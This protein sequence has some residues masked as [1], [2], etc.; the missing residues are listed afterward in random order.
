MVVTSWTDVVVG[1]LQNLWFGVANYLPNIIG[2]F[3]VLVVG[4]I[5]AAG[6]GALVEKILE[7]IRLDM[8]LE[9]VG[10]KPIF[11]RAGI[12]LR[13][14]YF[15]GKLVYW[16]VIVAFLLAVADSL[17]LYALSQFL[18]SILNYL[19]NVIAAVLIMLAALVLAHFLRKLVTASVMSAKLH[20]GPF[21]GTVTWWAIVVFGFL[22]ALTQ[23]NIASA[24][25][26]TIV[27]GFI[28]MLALAGG[29]AFGLGGKDYANHLLNKLKDRTETHI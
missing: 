28:A 15:F 3:V 11:E 14:A 26:Q 13:A 23:L 16:F 2:A 8:I 5:V 7:G 24:I 29:L 25:I 1:S 6:L 17:Q 20:S 9:K 18:T 22:T 19:P 10:L 12:K 4:L 27:T 21:L